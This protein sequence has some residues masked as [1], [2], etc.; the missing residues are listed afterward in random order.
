MK[1]GVSTLA[2]IIVLITS[3]K[4]ETENKQDPGAE[5]LL[6]HQP[7]EYMKKLYSETNF[8]ASISFI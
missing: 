8:L 5:T 4:I 3:C 1:I 7:H 2:G 6:P